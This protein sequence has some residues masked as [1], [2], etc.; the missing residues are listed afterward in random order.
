M[1]AISALQDA[2]LQVSIDYHGKTIS[3]SNHPKTTIMTTDEQPIVIQRM[4]LRTS[5][6]DRLNSYNHHALAPWLAQ[7]GYLTPTFL[8][9]RQD[10]VDEF[11]M[12]RVM[13]P[14]VAQRMLRR[15]LVV[16][17]PSREQLDQLL[18]V[19]A[20][21]KYGA[22]LVDDK[23][24]AESLKRISDEFPPLP[25]PLPE[26][27][28]FV[29][30]SHCSPKDADGGDLKPI[31]SVHEALVKIVSSK[32]TVQS[33]ISLLA[34]AS[35]DPKEEIAD[36][37]IFLSPYANIDKLSEWR[38]FIHGDQ[39]V[40]ISQTRFHTHN[41]DLSDDALHRLVWQARALWRDIRPS[42]GFD[43]CALD[44]YA[45]A[46]TSDFEL[47]LIEIN[48]GGPFLGSGSLLFH[49]LDDSDILQ[50]ETFQSTIVRIVPPHGSQ[51]PGMSKLGRDEAYQIGRAGIIQN[52]L[53]CMRKRGLAWVLDA[54]SHEKFMSIPVPGAEPGMYFTTRKAA[55]SVFERKFGGSENKS[56]GEGVLGNH[57]RFVKLQRAWAES[58]KGS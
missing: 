24:I 6:D 49:W 10:A 4:P 1:P 40:A 26:G 39:V 8:R 16:L 9:C 38:C 12:G 21:S 33:L 5:A 27:G 35:N 46:R 36:S 47:K 58:G 52:E 54:P 3:T 15:P 43:S 45:E 34:K 57:P 55:L 44:V 31:Y 53:E 19:A 13:T 20:R 56:T 42:L 50:P 29:R 41:Y 14:A 48:P 22:R 28:L 2:I 51:V 23:A 30:M 37:Q 18:G 11:N 17:R 25:A 32:R 7:T